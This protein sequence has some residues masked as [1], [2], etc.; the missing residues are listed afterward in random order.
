M[1][2]TFMILLR[3][4]QKMGLNAEALKA[5]YRHLLPKIEE[6]KRLEREAMRPRGHG[7]TSA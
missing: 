3:D 5:D 2:N 4:A 7:T 1:K 6:L